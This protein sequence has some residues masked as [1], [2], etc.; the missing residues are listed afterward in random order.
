MYFSKWRLPV[1][2]VELG[3]VNYLEEYRVYMNQMEAEAATINSKVPT[4]III[5]MMID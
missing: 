1:G 3:L 4:P 2:K 5:G